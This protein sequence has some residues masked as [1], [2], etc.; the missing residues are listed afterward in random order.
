MSPAAIRSLLFFILVAASSINARSD[1][2][3]PGSEW[4]TYD[5][6]DWSA[7][8]IRIGTAGTMWDNTTVEFRGI[9]EK[10]GNKSLESELEIHISDAGALFVIRNDYEA[11][12]KAKRPVRTCTYLGHTDLTLSSIEK[13]G[14]YEHQFELNGTFLCSDMDK[15]GT[16]NGHMR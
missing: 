7:T 15:V 6:L 10:P 2:A 13:Q 3:P 1:K 4:V 16:W 12:A 5:S 8:W 11:G 14:S 9:F